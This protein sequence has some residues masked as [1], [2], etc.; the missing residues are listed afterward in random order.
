MKG[1]NSYPCSRSAIDFPC[2]WCIKK[3]GP[4][5]DGE[6]QRKKPSPKFNRDF[7]KEVAAK[8]FLSNVLSMFMQLISTK[9]ETNIYI[10]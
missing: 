10:S 7:E 1:C 2:Q 3:P 6:E 8:I 4:T 5:N 9:I